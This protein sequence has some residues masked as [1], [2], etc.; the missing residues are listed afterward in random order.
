MDF[1]NKVAIA[2]GAASGM[3]LLFSQNFSALGG[4]ILMCDINEAALAEKAGEINESRKDS[5]AYAVCDVRDYAAVCKAVQKAVDLF[6]RIDVLVNFAGGAETRMCNHGGVFPDVPIEV[7]DWGIDVNL[8]GQLYFDHAVMK[9]MIA[10]Q[11]GVIINIGSIT[12]LEGCASE[13]AYSSAKSGAMYGLT[14]SVALAGARHGI[15]CNCV[16]PGPVMTRDMSGMKTIMGR[17]AQPQEIID[18][19]LFV[20]S[21]K[22]SYL[23]G[24]NILVDG[25]RLIT[26]VKQNKEYPI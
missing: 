23:T 12:G 8:K 2:T 20:A 16:A 17:A 5:A 24:E 14:R 19:V 4:K 9:Q 26:R 7:Y 1:H 11:S 13:V 21:D 22:A 6:G 18:V 25:G 10:Q 3:G 15:R